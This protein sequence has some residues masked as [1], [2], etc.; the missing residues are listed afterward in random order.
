MSMLLPVDAYSEQATL[1][2]LFRWEIMCSTI[3][4]SAGQMHHQLSELVVLARRSVCIRIALLEV[5]ALNSMDQICVTQ[6]ILILSVV[7]FT[8]GT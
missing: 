8:C 1:L 3:L 7:V 6:S 2:L 4:S 5:S